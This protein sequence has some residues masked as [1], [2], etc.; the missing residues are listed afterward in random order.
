MTRELDPI[1][2]QATRLRLMTALARNRDAA[3]VSLR[4]GLGLTD[5]NLA[6]HAERLV[7]AGYIENRRVLTSRGFEVR[8]RITP[9]GARA[10]RVYV[11]VLR[12]LLLDDAI[13]QPT[14]ARSSAGRR[15]NESSSAQEF[16]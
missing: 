14:A 15:D 11:D 13:P 3:W 2:H 1:I 4:D 10:F 6:S 9:A 16:S 5:G 8:L 12:D 7:Q